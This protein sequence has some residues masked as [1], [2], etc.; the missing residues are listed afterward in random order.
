MKRSPEDELTIYEKQTW[1][2]LPNRTTPV[3]KTRLE[4]IESGLDYATTQY[5]VFQFGAVGDGSTDD[6]L[7]IQAAVDAAE[8]AGGGV[9]LVPAGYTFMVNA[10]YGSG[11]SG[12]TG[13]IRPRAGVTIRVD[14]T[15][16]AEPTSN[17]SYAIIYGDAA[18][19]DWS[20]VGSGSIVGERDDHLG[21][22]GEFG[23]GI[24]INGGHN[25]VIQGVAIRDTW[26]DGI[27]IGLDGSTPGTEAENIRIDGV[28]IS[29][30]RR[31][32]ASVVAAKGVTFTGCVIVDVNGTAPESGIDLEPNGANVVSDVTITG[33]VIRDCAATG[34]VA[35]TDAVRVTITG[36]TVSGSGT[37]AGIQTNA[38]HSIVSGNVVSGAWVL[39]AIYGNGGSDVTVA[40]NNVTGSVG[41]GIRLLNAVH[42]T[43]VSGNVVADTTNTGISVSGS[44]NYSIVGN[45][46][47]RVST[48]AASSL[49]VGT[50]GTF[51]GGAGVIVGN[52][53]IDGAK[54]GIISSA[55]DVLIAD[56][57][58]MGCSA[59]ATNTYYGIYLADATY[60]L[61]NRI[62]NNVFRPS[63]SGVQL[64][65]GIRLLSGANNAWISDNDFLGAVATAEINDAATG[66]LKGRH[67]NNAGV[68]QEGFFGIA[69]VSRPAAYT[70]TFATAS[71]THAARTSAAT[72]TTTSTQTTPWGFSTQAQAN[73]IVTNLNAV[74]A[75]LDSSA[76]VLNSL[77]DD[78]QANGLI[79]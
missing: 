65:N 53:I 20:V 71:R 49:G 37:N 61:R 8:D 45:T 22:T 52:T 66:T 47:M 50:S 40:D 77:V 4:N 15:L 42:E 11:G 13:G 38:E 12:E 28:Q 59:D 35:A 72:V 29:N 7:A 74:R 19:S 68:I 64:M 70:Q 62:V 56:N 46:I 60:S 31:N 36:N 3:N 26:G 58:I 34:I 14:G 73:A 18:V 21:G 78:L 57:L 10:D 76:Q 54:S 5:N 75:D 1:E 2:N 33:C 17:G 55:P 44:K 27:Y 9:V 25:I 79:Q 63:G 16:Q 48:T 6:T 39:A 51:G 41:Y 67:R 32:G 23:M 69:P 43:T 30:V 24:R